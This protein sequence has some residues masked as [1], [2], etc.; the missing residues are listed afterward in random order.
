[1]YNPSD[2]DNYDFRWACRNGHNKTVKLLLEDKRVDPTAKD[3]Y[4]LKNLKEEKREELTTLI[5]H[6]EDI[7]EKYMMLCSY[8][9]FTLPID[10]CN[11]IFGFYISFISH[12]NTDSKP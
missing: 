5:L 6:V 2:E 3:N 1:M 7:R 4:S 9:N 8:N 12:K 10:I 11:I